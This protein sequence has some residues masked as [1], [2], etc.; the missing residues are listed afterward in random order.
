V[1]HRTI[2]ETSEEP[3]E[4]ER[5]ERER[6]EQEEVGRVAAIRADMMLLSNRGLSAFDI[7]DLHHV[8]PPTV[9]RWTGRTGELG[10]SGE[11]GPEG[12]FDRERGGRA[13]TIR[14]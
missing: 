6:R 5:A 11:Q 10:C 2:L 14:S 13:S 8:T 7:A 9:Y 3:F 12:L 1:S 4:E